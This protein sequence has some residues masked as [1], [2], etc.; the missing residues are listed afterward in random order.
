MKKLK[1]L[2]FSSWLHIKTIAAVTC[3]ALAVCGKPIAAL[4]VAILVIGMRK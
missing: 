3:L 4:S 2:S 1:D